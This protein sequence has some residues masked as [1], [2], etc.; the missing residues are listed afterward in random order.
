MQTRVDADVLTCALLAATRLQEHACRH[1]CC[2][3][4]QHTSW[5]PLSC[6]QVQCPA[7][8]A[9]RARGGALEGEAA[10][11]QAC[12]R[13]G[14]TRA[15]RQP[16]CLITDNQI[17]LELSMFMWMCQRICTHPLHPHTCQ[18]R[19]ACMPCVHSFLAAYAAC[20]RPGLGPEA[21]LALTVLKHTAC[22]RH[23]SAQHR[24]EAGRHPSGRGERCC[25]PCAQLSHTPL[26]CM[27]GEQEL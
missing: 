8:H 1:K 19:L 16:L 24:C 17:A 11:H 22:A 18:V 10:Q 27:R 12:C 6:L 5:R 14:R 9:E 23:C 20:T 2:C 26:F 7:A 25:R 3:G 4:C 15:R 13:I 21:V